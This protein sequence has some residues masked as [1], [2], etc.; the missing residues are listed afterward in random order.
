VSFDALLKKYSVY[1]L[2]AL[3]GAIAYFQ[4]AGTMQLLGASLTATVSGRN[5]VA[6]S[7]SPNAAP[8]PSGSPKDAEP[9]LARNAF[10][11]VT[12]P[13]NK[14]LSEDSDEQPPALDLSDPL[15]ASACEGIRAAIV[16]ESPDPVWSIAA[17]AGPGETSPKMRRI[18]DEVSGKQVAYIGYNSQEESPSVWLTSGAV[19]CQVLLFPRAPV[20]K[21]EGS[22]G[23][24]ASGAPAEPPAP[25]GPAKVPQDIADK[26]HKISDTEY[27]VD[28]SVVAKVMENQA[29]LMQ[30]ARII[31]ETKDGQVVGIRLFGI[32]PDTLLGSLGIQNGDRLETINGFSMSSPEKA[33]EAYTRLQAADGLKL[34]VNRRGQPVTV[35]IKFQ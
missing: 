27:Q 35:D 14:K 31:P 6:M 23:V 32:R 1:V 29:T 11:S 25:R 7:T 19:L 17:L 28:R 12:G 24:A 22:A 34:Q 15:G 20:A 26:I 10:D 18:G 5:T 13:L 21:P 3:V 4:A 9:I 33:L 30:S 8:I 16:T 2:L